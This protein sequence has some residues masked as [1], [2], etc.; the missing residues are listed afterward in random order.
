MKKL[1]NVTTNKK[2]RTKQTVKY[3]IINPKKQ[4]AIQEGEKILQR[5]KKA[6]ANKLTRKKKLLQRRRLRL[7]QKRQQRLQGKR[8]IIKNKKTNHSATINKTEEAIILLFQNINYGDPNKVKTQLITELEA[9]TL[10][11]NKTTTTRSGRTRRAPVR[12]R[13]N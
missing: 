5:S 2:K 4:E 3:T 13:N 12:F 10:N 9:T 11:T 1:R 6:K 7:K 8:I